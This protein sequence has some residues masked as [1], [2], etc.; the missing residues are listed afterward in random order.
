MR[1]E[2]YTQPLQKTLTWCRQNV[3][4]VIPNM[5]VYP[6]NYRRLRD[7]HCRDFYVSKMLW[8]PQYR[9][10]LAYN[11]NNFHADFNDENQT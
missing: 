4:N 7:E 8:R 6:Q 9:P 2:N 11:F 10:T 5:P 3:A 1:K